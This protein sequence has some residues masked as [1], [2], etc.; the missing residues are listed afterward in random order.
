[1][2]TKL[3]PHDLTV[4][5]GLLRKEQVAPAKDIGSGVK[6]LRAN[7][8]MLL[9]SVYKEEYLTKILACEDLWEAEKSLKYAMDRAG[10]GE[11]R[12]FKEPSQMP[13][14]A[15]STENTKTAK[16]QKEAKEPKAAKAPKEPKTPK[17]GGGLR[18]RESAFH[19]KFLFPL[20]ATNPRREGVPGWVSF[21]LIL[22][23]PGIT[24][25]EFLEKGGRLEDLRWDVKKGHVEVRDEK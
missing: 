10:N 21:G 23:K 14:S 13:E 22:K 19:G 16:A 11:V 7:L 6:R 3:T 25:K 4:L 8:G 15:M 1:M 5:I 12:K 20:M 9:G 17:E 24:T 18:G 2:D